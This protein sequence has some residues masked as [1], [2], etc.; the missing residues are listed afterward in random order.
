MIERRNGLR[1]RGAMA[2]R[3]FTQ[4]FRLNVV[5]RISEQ[6][7]WVVILMSFLL[8]RLVAGC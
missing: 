3:F 4:I 1:G 7:T 2:V 6:K 8:F 5:L